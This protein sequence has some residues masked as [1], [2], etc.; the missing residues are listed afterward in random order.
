MIIR[1]FRVI[2]SAKG[3]AWAKICLLNLMIVTCLGLLMRLNIVM[4]LPWLNQG[5]TLHA[6]SH[7]ALA[8]SQEAVSIKNWDSLFFCEDF[9]R[10]EST[11][12]I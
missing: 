7:F 1:L 12:R 4:T 8:G 3:T 9:H 5:F 6:H 2:D 11:V 10:L